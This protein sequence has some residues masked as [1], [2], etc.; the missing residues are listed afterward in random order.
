MNTLELVA[1]APLHTNVWADEAYAGLDAGIRYPVRLLHAHGI[2]TCQSCEGG[3]GHAYDLPS[4][5]MT[6]PRAFEAMS[7]L[8]VA[9]VPVR[10]VLS[11]WRVEHAVPDARIW[12]VELHKA[13][14]ER[15]DDRPMFIAAHLHRDCWVNP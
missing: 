11:I 12:R 13:L 2:P 5:D 7:V 8:E 4:I 15:A 6:E 3:E 14:P 10:S 1:K 9:A